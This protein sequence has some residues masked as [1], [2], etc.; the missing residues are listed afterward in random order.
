[1]PVK[2][3]VN[4][5]KNLGALTEAER[6]ALPVKKVGMICFNIDEDSFQMW[7]GSAWIN[8]PTA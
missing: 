5:E 7:N 2:S 1:M 4:V 8:I 3:F 6:D